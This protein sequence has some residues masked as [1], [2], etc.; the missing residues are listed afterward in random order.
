MPPSRLPSPLSARATRLLTGA[1]VLALSLGLS[2]APAVAISTESELR[3]ALAGGASTITLT[4]DI[5]LSSELT[6]GRDVT[7]EGGGFTIDGQNQTRLFFVESGSV[8][9][10]NTTLANGR[11]RGGD[12][13]DGGNGYWPGAGGGG[14]LGAGGLVFVDSA[15][16]VTLS[17]VTLGD[18]TAQGGAG[19]DSGSSTNNSF[20][21]GGGGGGFRGPSPDGGNGGTPS[22][23]GGSPGDGG[24]AGDGGTGGGGRGGYRTDDPGEPGEFGGGGGGGTDF[25]PGAAGRGGFGG[26]G[27]GGGGGTES[28]AGGYFGGAGGAGAEPDSGGNRAGG[29]GG[30]AGLGGA[31]FLRDGASLRIVDSDQTG[32]VSVSGGQG[33]TTPNGG[34]NGEDGSSAGAFS[35]LHRNTNL[36]ITSAA[37]QTLVIDAAD[38]L[39]G[40]GSLTK[41]GD[42]TLSLR[43]ASSHSGGT[44]L[45]A[46]LTEVG[47]DDALGSGRVRAD[48]GALAAIGGPVALANNVTLESGGLTVQ[49]SETL[50]L[51]GLLA[52]DGQLTKDGDGT[53]RLPGANFFYRGETRLNDGLLEV[54]DDLALGSGKVIGDGGALAATGGPVTL[55]NAFELRSGGMSVE[56]SDELTLS[57]DITGDGRL[58]KR[59]SGTL[60]LDGNADHRGGTNIEAGTLKLGASNILADDGAVTIGSGGTLDLAGVEETIGALTL[61][62]GRLDHGSSVSILRAAS[63]TFNDGSVLQVYI[64]PDATPETLDD[65]SSRLEVDGTATIRGGRIEVQAAPPIGSYVDGAVYTVMTAD[66]FVFA[67]G[68]TER[69]LAAGPHL[70]DGP[71]NVAQQI[72]AT[73]GFATKIETGAVSD[74][75]QLVLARNERSFQD[76]VTRPGLGGTA[77]ALDEMEEAGAPESEELRQALY[78]LDDAG[79]N[80]ATRQLGGASLPALAPMA[81]SAGR[82]ALAAIPTGGAGGGT[83]GGGLAALTQFAQAETLATDALAADMAAREG[84]GGT[85]LAPSGVWFKALG[86]FGSR[87]GDANTTGQDSHYA[88][89][90]GGVTLPLERDLELGLAL[91]GFA[92]RAEADDGLASTD[93]RSLMAAAQLAWT[94]GPWTFSGSFGVAGHRFESERRIAFGGFGA[95]AEGERDAIE[96]SGD[97]SLAY[98]IELGSLG[99]ETGAFTLTPIA[100]LGVSWL[101]EEAWE[102][103]GAPGANLDFDAAT[104]LSVQPRLGLGVATDLALEAGDPGGDGVLTLTPRAQALWIGELGDR[105]TEVDARFAG[106]G[107][108][109]RV[110]ALEAPEHSAALSLG[111]ELARDADRPGGW[112]LEAGY[113]GRFGDGAQDHG[114]LL[115]GGFK[116]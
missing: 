76:I 86:G 61:D 7:I 81:Q 58:G 64:E 34:N 78:G 92:G 17:N 5:A 13:G 110:P 2:A 32:T 9:I 69:D 60:V 19:G 50:T 24:T 22:S 42:G 67:D 97:L 20:G 57:G 115:K 102:E 31:I 4:G 103:T 27:G 59:G 113:A 45:E 23:G 37:N 108:A 89:G 46:G 12:G 79:V 16:D 53:L 6:V 91:A 80:S 83:G 15:G 25:R 35:F 11:A 26:G 106:A 40:P 101:R 82:A 1:S 84:A 55:D 49:G 107:T 70:P 51:S 62:G 98:D 73:F 21:G 65:N 38:A 85:A 111:A 48:G 74:A 30:G 88:G 96:L 94:P 75:L 33:G 68:M 54:G 29:G 90:A 8:T 99:S 14:G 36:E 10:Q 72:S 114:F 116:F 3:T 63:A 93:S 39:S 66:S 105:A 104:T 18:A 77:R 87:D 112:T 56:G 28:G 43:S 44:R 41:T 71:N 52:A 47:H 109:W 100:G 95:T